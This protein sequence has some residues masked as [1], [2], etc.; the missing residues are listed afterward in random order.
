MNITLKV[1]AVIFDSEKK[2]LMIKEKYNEVEEYKWNLVKG[3]FNCPDETLED[4]IRREIH[5]EVG[6]EVGHIAMKKIFHYG[7]IDSPKILFV[8]Y[9]YNFTGQV[10]IPKSNSAVPG[11]NIQTS[12]WFGRDEIR[13]MPPESFMAQYVLLALP[14]HSTG[15]RTNLDIRRLKN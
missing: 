7:Q 4:C 8:F 12:K 2:I 6:L 1:A 3:T 15:E 11:E 14:S 13:A 5:E 9:V 10:A